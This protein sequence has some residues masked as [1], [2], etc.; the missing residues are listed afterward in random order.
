MDRKRPKD[1][2]GSTLTPNQ[3][4][5]N[6]TLGLPPSQSSL[7][8]RSD[9]DDSSAGYI[10]ASSSRV[11]QLDNEP[12]TALPRTHFE[13]ST[14]VK[15]SPS[16][17]SP[18]SDSLSTT[19]G[20][21]SNDRTPENLANLSSV[22][23]FVP[24]RLTDL[25]SSDE[26]DIEQPDVEREGESSN[27]TEEFTP[28]Y[29]FDLRD[30]HE[31]T[32]DA[33][34]DDHD[35]N[36]DSADHDQTLTV[37]DAMEGDV[38]TVSHSH[39]TSFN[40]HN[41]SA[42]HSR[43]PSLHSVSRH[44]DK[45]HSSS[46]SIPVSLS[47]SWPS[48]NLPPSAVKFQ[49][50]RRNILI[51]LLK[52]WEGR[53]QVLHLTHSLVL[54]LYSSLDH[55]VPSTVRG[56]M[57]RPAGSALAMTFPKPVRVALMQRIYTSAEGIDNFRRVILIAR[58][59][60]F[61]TE[62]VMEHWQQRQSNKK[63][64]A[65]KGMNSSSTELEMRLIG[66]EP[67]DKQS[68]HVE[69]GFGWLR[70]PNLAPFDNEA[71]I[72]AEE[73]FAEK[74]TAK[75]GKITGRG[76]ATGAIGADVAEDAEEGQ[77]DEKHDRLS[78][79][80]RGPSA[81]SS[82][83]ESSIVRTFVRLWSSLWR[84][85]HLEAAADSLATVG[86]ACETAAVLAGGGMF[87]RAVGIQQ[88]GL[89]FLSRR[90][91]QGIERIGIVLSLCS[92]LLSLLAL[93]TERK[94][95]RSELRS[96]HRRIIRANDKLGWASDLAGAPIERDQAL[97]HRKRDPSRDGSRARSTRRDSQIGK[98]LEGA[99]EAPLEMLGPDLQAA[100]RDLDD[101]D[102]NDEEDG[103]SLSSSTSNL[104]DTWT[105]VPDGDDMHP[106]P[107]ARPTHTSHHQ[108]SY[109]SHHESEQPRRRGHRHH[110]QH[111]TNGEVKPVDVSS[112]LRST[113]RSLVRA[114]S[115]LRKT[116]RR[117]HLNFWAKVANWSEV[118]FLGYEAAMPHVDKEGV[119]GW[120]GLIASGVRLMGLW[121]E[122]SWN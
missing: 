19:T 27:D 30:P 25:A 56:A 95:L 114:E 38:I 120:T 67:F 43:S 44:H 8:V 81:K 116:R 77:Q 93:R 82:S 100:V 83:P 110:H 20:D 65:R 101:Q 113:E 55:P 86:E 73:S 91:R 85:S 99:S 63:Q 24:S 7:S 57:L 21:S 87:W 58:W 32:R 36:D 64:Q 29:E 121:K 26:D 10:T 105:V 16:A 68:D 102:L 98:A 76:D 70:P 107:T 97:S 31:R 80:G 22:T 48:L 115:D 34:W 3:H 122:L 45:P 84:V 53:E 71:K 74:P 62:A 78:Q 69:N 12:L 35:D 13:S 18:S 23:T 118:I 51:R 94:S 4:A 75:L 50:R 41:D 2:A 72:G 119:E 61:A 52:T 89:P 109:A 96:A 46:T 39:S 88:L 47:S 90:R 54:I 11:F 28:S 14:P 66:E 1:G 117:I 92:V 49:R 9:M 6:S 42:A 5:E 37:R 111:Q 108:H 33:Q 60:T 40:T 112:L 104:S 15:Q 79:Q 103:S 59:V 106:R 17:R